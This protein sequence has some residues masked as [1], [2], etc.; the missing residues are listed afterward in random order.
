MIKTAV[1]A[2]VAMLTT[3]PAFAC[4]PATLNAMRDQAR[5]AEKNANR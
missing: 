2:A 4:D 3:A 1:V 5:A